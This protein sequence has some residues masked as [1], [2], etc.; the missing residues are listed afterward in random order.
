MSQLK[1][2]S[3]FRFKVRGHNMFWDDPKRVPDWIKGMS[4]NDA[5]QVMHK[6]V[7]DMISHSM[8]T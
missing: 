3:L 7:N 5:L 1:S 6:R 8:G 4:Q 2:L